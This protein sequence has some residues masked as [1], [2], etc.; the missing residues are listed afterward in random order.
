[1]GLCSRDGITSIAGSPST[2]T[3]TPLDPSPAPC[4]GDCPNGL[5]NAQQQTINQINPLRICFLGRAYQEKKL[6]GYA[7]AYEQGWTT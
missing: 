4:D 1:M 3:K 6:L 5:P 7:Y 2:P